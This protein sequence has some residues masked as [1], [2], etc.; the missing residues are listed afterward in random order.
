MPSETLVRPDFHTAPS[1]SRTLGPEV[2]DLCEM[3]GFPPYPEQ[4]LILDDIFALDGRGRS[5]AFEVGVVSTRQQLKTGCL[6]QAALGWLF[7][8]DQP[9]IIWSAHEF[10]TAQEAFRDMHTLIDGSDMLSRRVKKVST[11]NGDEAIELTSGAR[12]RFKARTSGGGRGLTGHKVILD[13]AFA[14]QPEHMG[15]LLPTLI[16]VPDPQVVYGSSAGLARSAILRALR[17]RGRAGGERLAYLEWLSERQGCVSQQCPHTPGFGGCVM[18][19]VDLWR[20]ACPITARKF[21]DM[22]P[23]RA[24]RNALPPDEFARECLGWWDESSG[25]SPI[26]EVV[27]AELL[28]PASELGVPS[29]GLDV[30]PERDWS[31]IGVAGRAGQSLTHVEVTADTDG[32]DH[33]EGV[34]WVLPRLLVMRESWGD[35][36]VVVAAGTAVESLLPAIEDA[37]VRVRRL[38][39]AEVVAACGMF[40]DLAMA[41]TLR[42][43]GQPDL[44][45][46]VLGARKKNLADRA[47]TWMRRSSTPITPLYAVTYASWAANNGDGGV[48]LW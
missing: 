4:R 41:R 34:A 8:T 32:Y 47:F 30:S 6:K 40:Y 44:T 35:F 2:S 31:T 5:A 24:L 45:A 26:P 48:I 10:G 37:G 38:S 23:I 1:Y 11:G 20:K 25:E 28:D 29:F 3:V 13:E 16:A 15:A 43:L 22:A 17:D 27:W 46:A 42:H 21:P 7:V 36:E 18:D 9:L 39:P 12:L 19:D 14:L 33:R